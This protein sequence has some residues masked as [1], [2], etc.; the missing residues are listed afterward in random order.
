MKFIEVTCNL[1]PAGKRYRRLINVN[2]IYDIVSDDNEKGSIIR[3]VPC[4]ETNFT[5]P[6][7]VSVEESYGQIK[8]MLQ[9]INV[10]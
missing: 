4:C 6:Q 1:Y 5:Q 10:L 8:E 9:C 3:Y 2:W 7:S